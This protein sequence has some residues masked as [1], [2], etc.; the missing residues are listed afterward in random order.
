MSLPKSNAPV[1]VR[2]TNID[3]YRNGIS[4]SLYVMLFI[5]IMFLRLI[6]DSFE[7]V[8]NIRKDLDSIQQAIQAREIKQLKEVANSGK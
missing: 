2:V 5:I 4:L 6:N 1:E 8:K 7:E 3:K